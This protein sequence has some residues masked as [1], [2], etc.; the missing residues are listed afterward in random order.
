MIPI[1]DSIPCNTRPYV[2]WVLIASCIIIFLVMQFLLSLQ[3]QHYILHMYGIVPIRYSN[4]VWAMSFGLAPDH[5][6]SFLTSLF[7]HGGWLHLILNVWFIWIFA[8]NIEDRMG[9]GMFLIFYLLCG[10][11]S[12]LIQW[13]F[14]PELTIPVVGASGAIA[15]ILAAYF[16][17]FP[18]ARIII[19]VPIFLLPIFVEIPAIAFLGFWMILQIH[20]ATTSILFEG[21][22]ATVAW[23]AHVGGFVAGAILHRLFLREITIDETII[24]PDSEEDSTKQ[25]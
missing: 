17:L 18:Y 12:M 8:K 1:R 14:S 22:S 9:H 11:T 16:F 2:S 19:W 15:G 10:V 5:G 20:E 21:E 6:L 13:Y 24:T 4:P 3:Q 25:E 7:L 23:W